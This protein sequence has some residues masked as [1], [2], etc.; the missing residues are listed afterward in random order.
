MQLKKSHLLLMLVVVMA[1]ILLGPAGTLLAQ[2]PNLIKNGSFEEGFITGLGVAN[3]WGYFHSGN[4]K[5]GFYDDT[6]EFV[7]PDGEHAQL[8]ELID[9]SANDTYAGIYQKVP[10]EAG[11]LYELSFKGLIRSTEGSIKA[12][13]YGYRMQYAI[14]QTGN[15]DWRN[16]TAW[17]ELP[18]DEQ[19]RTDPANGVFTIN[20][21]KT[22]FTAQGDSVTIFIRGWKKWADQSEGN[23]DIDAVKL[24]ALNA[25]PATTPA[26]TVAVAATAKSE[27]L[28]ET[29]QEN[30]S[31][32]NLP[33]V[34]ASALLLTLLIGGAL[35]RKRH[36]A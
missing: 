9:A 28:P 11:Q 31:T 6:W 25:E 32:V 7:V 20:S 4:V 29:G 26:P 36:Q 12:S 13:N 19:P 15:E 14:D 22:T 30:T 34:I 8:I 3:Q 5:A 27:P 24:V 21:L 2:Q 35:N 18:W 10:V 17:T 23:Y 33:I 16:V 1:L